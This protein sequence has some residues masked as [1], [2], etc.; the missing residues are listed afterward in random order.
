MRRRPRPNESLYGRSFQEDL[1]CSFGDGDSL[2]AA[3]LVTFL[4]HR[5][6][7]PSAGRRHCRQFQAEM[8]AR[9]GRR[10]AFLS[11]HEHRHLQAG[12]L[13]QGSGLSSHMPLSTTQM[14]VNDQVT[15]DAQ[16]ATVDA[17]AAAA[18][19]SLSDGARRDATAHG[20][21][22]GSHRSAASTAQSRRGLSPG[23]GSA[24]LPTPFS[25]FVHAS[26]RNSGG[27]RRS[28]SSSAAGLAQVRLPAGPTAKRQHSE[29][30]HQTVLGWNLN[31]SCAQH[32]AVHSRSTQ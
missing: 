17:R 12:W 3:N 19:R 2:T 27:E 1:T 5:S 24:S 10:S 16:H 7:P 15:S 11:W 4:L 9:A 31:L 14:P 22:T 13:G 8:L 21:F 6:A 20:S 23:R 32:L 25:S 28:S 30:G 18:A 26:A 29:T